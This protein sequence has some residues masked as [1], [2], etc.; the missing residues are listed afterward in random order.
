MNKF[1]QQL[2][3]RLND[4]PAV[5]ELL[6]SKETQRLR[7]NYSLIL[8][9]T[10][11]STAYYV[12]V[13]GMLF[14]TAIFLS[15]EYGSATFLSILGLSAVGCLL[16]GIKYGRS[17]PNAAYVWHKKARNL[18]LGWYGLG[19]DFEEA[20]SSLK[21]EVIEM[22]TKLGATPA[23]VQ[24]LYAAAKDYDLPKQWWNELEDYATEYTKNEIYRQEQK[25]EHLQQ[26]EKEMV[27]RL[28]INSSTQT[29]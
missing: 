9:L 1:S 13:C 11:T 24:Q 20:S 19:V 12:M 7:N 17:I 29:Y 10:K 16:W 21:V 14:V 27:A 8:D 28:K 4:L 3:N 6:T 2:Q 18:G 25:K 5:K 22:C 26:L 15:P 23:Q